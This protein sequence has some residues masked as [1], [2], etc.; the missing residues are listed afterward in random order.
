[1]GRLGFKVIW[2]IF[3]IEVEIERIKVW[4]TT[5]NR[6]TDFDLEGSKEDGFEMR[7]QGFNNYKKCSPESKRENGTQMTTADKID[8]MYRN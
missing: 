5:F 1:M 2:I 6:C 4:I 8:Q 3:K 7:R